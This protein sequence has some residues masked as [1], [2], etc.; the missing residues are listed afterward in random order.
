MFEE[1]IIINKELYDP[2]N[3]CQIIKSIREIRNIRKN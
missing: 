2:D 3:S 1:P